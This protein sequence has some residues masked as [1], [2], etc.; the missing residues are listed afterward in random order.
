MYT[1][2]YRPNTYQESKQK[3]KE[4]LSA[5]IFKCSHKEKK[6]LENWGMGF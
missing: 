1:I 3:D 6:A 2:L 4:G 5:Q